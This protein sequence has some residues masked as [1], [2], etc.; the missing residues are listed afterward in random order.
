M[1]SGATGG[2]EPLFGILLTVWFFYM[3]LEAYHTCRKRRAG[4]PVDEFSSI[5]NVRGRA[6][7]FPAGALTLIGLGVVLLMDTMGILRFHDIARYWPV[8]LILAGV[9]LLYL[10]LG[11]S[12][13]RNEVGHERH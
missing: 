12:E 13:A 4:E 1:N 3:S 5:V 9:Y 11:P 7:A 10:R 6:G 2:M 8:L